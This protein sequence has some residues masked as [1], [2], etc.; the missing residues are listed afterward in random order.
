MNMILSCLHLRHSD[1]EGS[2]MKTFE[3]WTC[4]GTEYLAVQNRDG[5]GWHIV[6]EKGENFGAWMTVAIFRK[7]QAK[8]DPNGFLGMP[9]THGIPQI[10]PY[11]SEGFKVWAKMHSFEIDTSYEKSL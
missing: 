5:D 4:K 9:G 6:D 11:D 8:D 2:E 7:L 10:K 3:A 1:Q